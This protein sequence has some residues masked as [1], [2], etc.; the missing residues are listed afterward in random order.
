M[1]IP[2][3]GNFMEKLSDAAT[4]AKIIFVSAAIALV[5]VLLAVGTAFAIWL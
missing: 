3:W 4:V 2:G 1:N 5:C